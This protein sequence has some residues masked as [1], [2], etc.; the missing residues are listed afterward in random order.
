MM[1][2][3]LAPAPSAGASASAAEQ[4]ML[5]SRLDGDAQMLHRLL[6]AGFGYVTQGNRCMPILPMRRAVLQLAAHTERPR[7]LKSRRKDVA[8]MLRNAPPAA[9]FELRVSTD[10]ELACTQLKIHHEDSWVGPAL[11]RVWHRMMHAHTSLVVL[12]LWCGGEMV[13]A[14]FGHPVGRSFY[15]ATRWH[16]SALA[17]SQPGFV[18][19]LASA[20][21]LAAHGY[22]LW[23]L[24]GTDSS[25]G[26]KY[27]ESV[28]EILQ[29]PHFHDLF[30]RARATEG[31][32]AAGPPAK[33]IQPGLAISAITESDLF[34]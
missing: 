2:Y 8:R 33:R 26:M 29:R 31:Q 13:A 18:L 4:H 28:A 9:P 11:L 23:D 34:S 27:K 19:A 12:E 6:Q 3:S 7:R 14:D 5:D 15:V 21:L 10:L 24:G 25:P 1:G 20:K 17:K 16:D 30:L 32:L 22:E